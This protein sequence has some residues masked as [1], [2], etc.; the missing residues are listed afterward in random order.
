MPHLVLPLSG[1]LSRR[2]PTRATRGEAMWTQVSISTEPF[3]DVPPSLFPWACRRSVV[4]S[5]HSGLVPMCLRC[6]LHSCLVSFDRVSLWTC[7]SPKGTQHD[8]LGCVCCLCLA[9]RCGCRPASG[10]STPSRCRALVH[11]QTPMVLRPFWA[12]WLCEVVC[13]NRGRRGHNGDPSGS[14]S[15]GRMRVRCGCTYLCI[16]VLAMMGYCDRRVGAA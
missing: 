16:C 8:D 14:G 5:P 15:F 1:C 11:S 10:V 2:T 12:Q 9:S 3:A 7:G 6:C 4:S 13:G